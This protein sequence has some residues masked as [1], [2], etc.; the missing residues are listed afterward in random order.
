MFVIPITKF[1]GNELPSEK[2]SEG[3]VVYDEEDIE[4]H[5]EELNDI[6]EVTEVPT[7]TPEETLEPAPTPTPAPNSGII[8]PSKSDTESKNIPYVRD[9]L[10]EGVSTTVGS[11]VHVEKDSKNILV[12]GLNPREGCTDT[13]II[14]SICDRT[15]TVQS[16][17]LSRDAYVPYGDTV[18]NF[19]KQKGIA[20]SRGI[21]KLNACYTIGNMMHYSGGRFSNSG[22]SFLVYIIESMMPNSNIHIDD[23]IFMNFDG[24]IEIINMFGGADVYVPEDVYL[25]GSNGK[26]YLKWTKGTHHMDANEA[27]SFLRKR[28]R[29]NENGRI[30]SSGDPYR[31]ANQ[32]RFVKDF[33][34]QIITVENVANANKYLNKL[35]KNVF[36]SFNSASKITEYSKYA[37][38]FAKGKYNITSLVVSGKTI[39]PVGD[40]AAYKNLMN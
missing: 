13:I 18:K 23:Y 14:L 26:T 34:K 15:K 39:D 30:S 2:I 21:Y 4:I 8:N 28:Y 7:P 12:L 20:N 6:P 29:Y 36:H 37:T 40:H 38:D 33:A 10:V 16:L 5:F 27:F 32:L 19:L 25:M 35:S 17:S 9:P 31:K 24:C 22:I 11:N 3:D 1:M